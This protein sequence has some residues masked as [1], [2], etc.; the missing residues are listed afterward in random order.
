MI[1]NSAIYIKSFLILNISIILIIDSFIFISNLTDI[2]VIKKSAW[3]KKTPEVRF[4]VN[5][6][7]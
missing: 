3:I 5:I 7:I 1:K 2:S 6:N 4:N